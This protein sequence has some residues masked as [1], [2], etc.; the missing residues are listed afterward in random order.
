MFYLLLTLCVTYLDQ[1]S[2][3]VLYDENFVIRTIGNSKVIFKYTQLSKVVLSSSKFRYPRVIRL[4]VNTVNGKVK[5]YKF[6]LPSHF[7]DKEVLKIFTER[8][9]IVIYK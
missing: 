9:V 2:D 7:N 6:L 3:F 1:Y 4:Y 8:K 5:R